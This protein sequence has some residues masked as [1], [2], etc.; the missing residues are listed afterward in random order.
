M[1][2]KTTLKSCV[3]CKAWESYFSFCRMFVLAHLR[4]PWCALAEPKHCYY[5]VTMTTSATTTIKQSNHRW[6]HRKGHIKFDTFTCHHFPRA[7]AR[8]NTKLP[9][10]STQNG[11]IGTKS[12]VWVPVLWFD[13]GKHF[14]A[15]KPINFILFFPPEINDLFLEGV[16]HVA[17]ML[18]N[19]RVYVNWP[20]GCY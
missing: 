2:A 17:W 3:E 8:G 20:T 7:L 11:P 12:W 1:A 14:L 9:G 5:C 16:N 4:L 6:M 10:C 15:L 13:R 19:V 18:E